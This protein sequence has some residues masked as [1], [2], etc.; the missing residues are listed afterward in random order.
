MR[1][2]ALRGV[3]LVV[4]CC[5]LAVPAFFLS[6]APSHLPR[7]GM[8]VPEGVVGGCLSNLGTR[9]R[10]CASC[11]PGERGQSRRNPPQISA[12][13]QALVRAQISSINRGS[14]LIT[15]ALVQ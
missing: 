13:P 2:R 5:D 7:A 3:L 1:R 8:V 15:R 14:I 4:V 6:T 12:V 11:A 10:L 9:R